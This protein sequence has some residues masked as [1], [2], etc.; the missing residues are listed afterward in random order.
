MRSR[1]CDNEANLR[2][3]AD[4]VV[5]CEPST[6]HSGLAACRGDWRKKPD[7]QTR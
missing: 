1:A 5:Q 4:T 7:L 2:F 3:M 6:G